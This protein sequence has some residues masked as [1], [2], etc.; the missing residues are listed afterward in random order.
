MF[1]TWSCPSH[2]P[3]L[4]AKRFDDLMRRRLQI[5]QMVPDHVIDLPG[6]L[7]P[8]NVDYAVD[9]RA[10]QERDGDSGQSVGSVMSV[11]A[12]GE[13]RIA[14]SISLRARLGQNLV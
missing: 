3:R 11:G 14:R 6:R 7:G 8:D 5:G 10:L 4:I 9:A 2:S 1:P 12:A 13:R